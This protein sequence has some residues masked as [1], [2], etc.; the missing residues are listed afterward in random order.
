[1]STECRNSRPMR[2][3]CVPL[4]L[5]S[6]LIAVLHCAAQPRAFQSA[7]FGASMSCVTTGSG[8]SCARNSFDSSA[9][10]ERPCDAS[11]KGRIISSTEYTES[12]V[13]FCTTDLCANGV[14]RS[15]RIPNSDHTYRVQYY[16]CGDTGWE[17]KCT[18][19]T[20][21]ISTCERS[22]TSTTC[23]DCNDQLTTF[24]P[25]SLVGPTRSHTSQPEAGCREVFEKYKPQV[26]AERT[27]EQIAYE[28]IVARAALARAAAS[29][30][31]RAGS[32]Q[33][34]ST[35]GIKPAL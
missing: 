3:V 24:N 23:K 8:Q 33:S 35:Q 32:C 1:M 2:R 18:T 27:A 10:P 30:A 20:S 25:V 21:Y 6:S 4:A 5:V 19:Q 22:K 16:L 34:N 29:S 17:L 7:P 15:D 28:V 11:T 13:R 14:R 26:Q 9:P 12:N 31:P